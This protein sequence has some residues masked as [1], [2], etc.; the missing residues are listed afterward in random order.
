MTGEEAKKILEAYIACE[1][2]K[3]HFECSE[4]NCGDDCPLLYEMGT[5]GEYNEAINVAIQAL[6]QEPCEDA[7]SRREAIK[8]FTYNYKGE[9]IPNYDCDNFPVQIAMKTVKKMLR[10]LPP[11]NLQ[12][13]IGHWIIIGDRYIKCSECGHITKT[14]SPDIYH[15]CMVCGAKMSEEPTGSESE[16]EG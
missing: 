3:A 7:I 9:R 13:K 6:E 14:E 8:M 11:V 4:Y 12:E 10:E 15:F 2:K 1:S 16:V 5:V